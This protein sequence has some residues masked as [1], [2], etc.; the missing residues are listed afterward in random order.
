MSNNADSNIS[1]TNPT[2]DAPTHLSVSI[3]SN[4][5]LTPSPSFSITRLPILKPLSPVLNYLDWTLVIIQVL[6]KEKLKYVLTSMD[7][8]PRP[9]TWEDDS[10]T[11]C[12]TIMQIVD[13]LNLCYIGE[14]PDNAPGMWSALSRAHQDSSTGGKVYWMRKLVNTRMEGDDI[15]AHIDQLAKFH[16]RLNALVTPEKP[17]TPDNFHIVAL[18]SS[19]PPNWIHCV[20]GLMNQEGVKSETIVSALKNESI[21]RESQG[22]I[23]SV[24][25][26][27]ATS[28]P[29]KAKSNQNRPPP[30]KPDGEKNSHRC[31]LCNT[32]SHDLNACNNTCQL[33]PDHKAAQKA[34]WEASH[35]ES[36][37]P[38]TKPP[39]WAGRTSAATL[40]QTSYKYDKE[41]SDYSGSKVKVTARNAV[42]SLS[43]TLGP[44]GSGKQTSTPDVLC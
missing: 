32:D 3:V 15:T 34:R 12:S 23:I 40:G 38:S 2:K 26:T 28:K 37:T 8:K 19:I 7:I 24:L 41:E 1:P 21:C 4:P 33:I 16:K 10:N 44:L 17:L 31:P 42:T 43:S 36:P 25:S 18:L 29:F 35:Q 20:S 14:T 6:K 27:L 39:A 11:V 13:P 22:N 9:A 30:S 5:M